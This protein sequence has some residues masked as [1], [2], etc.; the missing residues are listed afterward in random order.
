MDVQG[1]A[2][3]NVLAVAYNRITEYDITGKKVWDLPLAT[4]QRVVKARRLPNGNVLAMDYKG[5]LREYGENKKVV[6]TWRGAGQ[7]G[8]K[9]SLME[10]GNVLVF[11]TRRKEVTELGP[12]GKSVRSVAIPGLPDGKVVGTYVTAAAMNDSGVVLVSDVRKR[13][14]LAFSAETGKELW[15]TDSI[16]YARSIQSLPGGNFLVVQSDAVREISPEGK[17]VNI[18]RVKG[19]FYGA[20]KF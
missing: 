19:T 5:G 6:K 8:D 10:N 7:S 20:H 12:D 17:D 1:L 14:L 16:N 4:N 11:S 15:T 2:N 3:G 13:R 18:S 9:F